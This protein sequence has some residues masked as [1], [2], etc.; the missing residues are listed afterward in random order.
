MAFPGFGGAL[1]NAGAKGAMAE[2]V[3]SKS[4]DFCAKKNF[5][6][7]AECFFLYASHA[8]SC[9]E[10]TTVLLFETAE[11]TSQH[12]SPSYREAPDFKIPN[13]TK[14][15]FLWV[16]RPPRA[17]FG[18]PRTEPEGVRTHSAV[19]HFRAQT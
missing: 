1:S 2:S 6:S 18:A 13:G 9:C 4:C 19:S 3:S 10:L 14:E 11:K 5:S 12:Q 15:L 8:R 7:F 16:A 17:P